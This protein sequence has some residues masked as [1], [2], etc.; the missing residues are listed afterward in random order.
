[1]QEVGVPPF[2]TAL[3]VEP[4][5]KRLEDRAA[6][7][8]IPD[9]LVLVLADGAGGRPGGAEAADAVIRL[10]R[11]AIGSIGDPLDPSCWSA[12]LGDIDQEIRGDPAA[13]ETT[14]VVMAVT[15]R[16]LAGASVGDSG[17]WLIRP[18]G[19]TDLTARQERKPGLGTGVARAV[20]FACR[21]L[22]GTLLVASDGL[23]KYTSPERICLT[24]QDPNLE[25]G[26]RRLVDLVRLRSGRLPDDVGVILCRRLP[27][28]LS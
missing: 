5:E 26:V 6:I 4:A 28:P 27:E 16:G 3:Y 23:L 24:A 25:Q 14:A 19:M 22:W 11:A 15:P 18:D 20:P 1:M 7:I 8:P 2:A 13:G 17:A 12:L 21:E 10:A 9:G